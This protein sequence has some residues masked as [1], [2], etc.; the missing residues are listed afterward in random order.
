MKES[1]HKSYD[2]L[3]LFLNAR[4][5]AQVLGVSVASGYELMHEADFPHAAGGQPHGGAPGAVHPMGERPYERG[6]RLMA[7]IPYRRDPSVF[8]FPLPNRIWKHHLK[9]PDFSVLAYLHYRHHRELPGR[10]SVTELTGTL[11]LKP[12]A[13]RRILDV[14]TR[15]GARHTGPGPVVGREK[16]FSLPDEVFYLN[17]GSAAIAV[18]AFL[19]YR[20]KPEDLSVHTQLQG[21][22][23]CHRRQ[24]QHRAQVRAGAGGGRTHRH[25]PHR[26]GGRGRNGAQRLSALHDPAGAKRGGTA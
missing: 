20:G 5:V 21:H 8:R 19:L 15:Q 3:P 1:I 22:W 18:Y 12:G 10:A 17:L 26:G 11:G 6:R 9:Y 7:Y 13:V 25:Q 14:L 24:Q 4:T 2:D 23:I 16:Y